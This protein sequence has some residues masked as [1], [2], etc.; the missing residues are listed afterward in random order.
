MKHLLVLLLAF[1][2]ACGG[3]EP[4]AAVASASAKGPKV[5]GYDLRRLRPRDE[6]KLADMFERMRRW[7]GQA[8]SYPDFVVLDADGKKVEE[9]RDAIDR[10][11]AEG[12]EPTVSNWFRQMNG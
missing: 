3:D 1:A 5:V 9:M 6:E 7:G 8:N 2:P 12:T 4:T 11:T 10:L